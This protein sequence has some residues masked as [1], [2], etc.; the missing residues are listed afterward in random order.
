M[1]IGLYYR[2][3]AFASYSIY[4]I[5][6]EKFQE[7]L[8]CKCSP[9][10]QTDFT[11]CKITFVMRLAL[12]HLPPR[13]SQRF[14]II[15]ESDPP[16]FNEE[17]Y[18]KA[19]SYIT[20]SSKIADEYPKSVLFPLFAEPKY[21][22]PNDKQKT[23]DCVFVGKGSHPFILDR[24]KVVN[25]LREQGL[26]VHTYGRL[27][28]KHEHSFPDVF[29]QNLIDAYC[30]GHLS[31]DLCDEDSAISSRIYQAALCGITTITEPR[32]TMM[33]QFWSEEEL[34]YAESFNFVSETVKLLKDKSYLKVVGQN[35][36]EKCL[37]E[38]TTEDFLDRLLRL[39]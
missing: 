19:E 11:M 16:H 33:Q 34:F 3:H 35:V 27:W 32:P 23:C 22:K 7:R 10:F 36:R 4:R 20:T 9:I 17:F 5:L 24:I 14:I 12:Q 2:K 8:N 18:N 29:G 30:S 38:Y 15:A 37:Q 21:F 31:L 28:P 26:I 1:K 13:L 6:L 25:Q 39:I